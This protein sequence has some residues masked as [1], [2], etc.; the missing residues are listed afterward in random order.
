MLKIVHRVNTIEQLKNIPSEYGVEV[1]IRADEDKLVL[2]HDPFKGGEDFA[3]YLKEYRQAFLVLNIKE[4]GI[5]KRVIEMVEEK[6]IKD[7]FL[8]DVEFCYIYKRTR[9]GK[10]HKIAVRYSEAEPIEQALAL[11]DK[12][13]WVWIDTNTKLPFDTKNF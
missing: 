8:L 11:K 4:I 3:V 13:E 9:Y 1:D 12:V 5:E 10:Q 7:Y 2:H 6:G